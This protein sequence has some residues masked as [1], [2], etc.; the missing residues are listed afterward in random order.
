VEGPSLLPTPV[1]EN[2][3]GGTSEAARYNWELAHANRV[4]PF[5]RESAW[6]RQHSRI[7]IAYHPV[8]A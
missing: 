1:F 3:E 2:Q 8:L 7:Y 6:P 4:L 5:W